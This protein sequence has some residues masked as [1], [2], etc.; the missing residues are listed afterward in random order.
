MRY[1]R[2]GA[3][4]EPSNM[5]CRSGARASLKPMGTPSQSACDARESVMPPQEL[6]TTPLLRL[7]SQHPAPMKFVKESSRTNE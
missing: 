7:H 1:G 5:C 3:T 6:R 2:T 4:E